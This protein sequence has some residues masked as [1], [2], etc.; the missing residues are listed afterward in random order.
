MSTS[1]SDNELLAFL[2]ELLPNERASAIEQTLRDSDELRNRV[3]SLIRRR[4]QGGHTV[5]EIWRRY[6]LTCP[7]RQT[8]GSYLLGVPDEPLQQY[9][10]FHLETIGCR[11][12][13]ATVSEL[14]DAQ[15]ADTDHP[16]QRRRRYFES[17]A[18]HLKRT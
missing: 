10:Q 5:G 15:A 7:D 18:G 1:F 8:L 13:S 4:D 16:T 9:I 3:A 11:L 14:E 17:S 12:C 2:D 6:R